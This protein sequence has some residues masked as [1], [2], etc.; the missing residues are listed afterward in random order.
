M[1]KAIAVIGAAFGDEGKGLM[2][3]YFCRQA[4]E[5][6]IVV[7][8]N[9]GAQ[10]GHTVV[11]PEGKRHVFHHYGAGHLAGAE[12]YLSRFFLVNPALWAQEAFE[13]SGSIIRENYPKL[14]VDHFAL[15]TTPYDMF[16]NQKLEERR[17]ESFGDKRHGSCGMGIHETMLRSKHPSDTRLVVRDL[18]SRGLEEKLDKIRLY[19][20]G[21]LVFLGLDDLENIEWVNDNYVFSQCLRQFKQFMK[22]AIL[23]NPIEL[24]Q[25][26]VIFEGA[27]GLL[28]DQ[29]NKRFFP[30]VTHSKTGLSNACWLAGKEM[31]FD[32]LDVCYVARS[33][34][35]RHGHGELPGGD[36]N[37]S[38]EDNTNVQN[39]WQGSLR[40]APQ[41]WKLINEAMHEDF[42]SNCGKGIDLNHSI[43]VTHLDQCPITSEDYLE[44]KIAVDY[45]SFGPTSNDVEKVKFGE[46]R[47]LRWPR[48]SE[49]CTSLP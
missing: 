5:Q 9:G 27:Q 24:S 16:I 17:N 20:I 15:V 32:K 34:L 41:D 45:H 35:T 48:F 7:R 39:N 23:T 40:F 36:P 30:H 12:T 38:Y 2:T 18:I 10:A 13:L 31:G 1:K 8:F 43:A 25:K 11:T 19:A 3:D 29:D 22:S 6:P 33:Y 37:L 42:N 28:L 14:L 4:Q 49:S 44:L 21:R 46:S 26:E 47:G